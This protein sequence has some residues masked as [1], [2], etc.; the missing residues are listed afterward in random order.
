MFPATP[1]ILRSSRSHPTSRTF[2]PRSFEHP[3]ISPSLVPRILYIPDFPI[4]LNI[5]LPLSLYS[6]V[7]DTPHRQL[8][9]IPRYACSA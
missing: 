1:N 7:P 4:H 6:F 8:L 3:V 5:P 9:P 2:V